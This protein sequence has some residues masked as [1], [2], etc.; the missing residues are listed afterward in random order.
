MSI[1]CVSQRLSV[2]REPNYNAMIVLVEE[3][4]S[5][6]SKGSYQIFSEMRRE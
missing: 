6:P 3:W 1:E 5:K 4:D 2:E